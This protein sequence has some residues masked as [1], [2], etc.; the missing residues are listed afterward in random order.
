[1]QQS[2]RINAI[3]V[4]G[5][6]LVASGNV[7]AATP[8]PRGKDVINVP[9]LVEGLCVHNGEETRDSHRFSTG[10]R[11]DRRGAVCIAHPTAVAS[12]LFDCK[13]RA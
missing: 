2:S 6:I 7:Y 13:S 8:L 12:S 3:I 1:M 4:W 11:Q 10:G 5:A 9:A